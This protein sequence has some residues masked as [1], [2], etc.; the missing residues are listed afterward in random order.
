MLNDLSWR[1][2]ERRRRR[3]ERTFMIWLIV[4]ALVVGIAMV[5]GSFW[6]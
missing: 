3:A 1:E 5:V 2:Y 4:A 6:P